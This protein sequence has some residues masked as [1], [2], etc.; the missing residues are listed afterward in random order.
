LIVQ[1]VPFYF[2]QATKVFRLWCQQR[3][4]QANTCDELV[5]RG[6]LPLAAESAVAR[7]TDVWRALER[8]HYAPR[9]H[10]QTRDD[11]LCVNVLSRLMLNF[12][13]I[14]RETL[15][16]YQRMGALAPGKL[17]LK[18]FRDL[19]LISAAVFFEASPSRNLWRIDEYLSLRVE[20]M[21]E[22]LVAAMQ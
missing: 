18:G 10:W 3:Q 19:L 5:A 16:A 15:R 12:L 6:A 22:K 20:P 7:A 1:D 2:R 14:H 8:D 13:G 21:C 9:I 11:K 4:R 17:P